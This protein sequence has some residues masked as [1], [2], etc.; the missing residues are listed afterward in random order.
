MA[1]TPPTESKAAAWRRLTQEMHE[2]G[3][4]IDQQAPG[5]RERLELLRRQ[6]GLSDKREALLSNRH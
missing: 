5:T 1:S 3:R 4:T 2:L 6:A